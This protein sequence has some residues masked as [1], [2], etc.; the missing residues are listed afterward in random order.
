MCNLGDTVFLCFALHSLMLYV[1]TNLNTNHTEALDA[2]ASLVMW[3][4][5]LFHFHFG[6]SNDA[7]T[8][9]KSELSKSFLCSSLYAKTFYK[10]Q[11]NWIFLDLQKNENVQGALKSKCLFQRA[12]G[13][14]NFSATLLYKCQR[15]AV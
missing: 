2:L 14:S 11:I 6:T 9:C 1:R 10:V 3:I 4:L 5:H 12:V 13:N 8:C 7:V 15:A